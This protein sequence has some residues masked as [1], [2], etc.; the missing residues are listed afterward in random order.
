MNNEA[1]RQQ[2]L[3]RALWGDARP[4]VV[5]GWLRGAPQRITRGLQAYRAN[6][7]ALAERAL[8]AAFPT[9]AQLVGEESFAALARAFWQAQAPLKGDIAQW[10]AALPAFIAAAPQLADEPY[11]ADVARLDWAVHQAEQAAD[12]AGAVDGLEHLAACDPATLWLHL[13]DGVALIASPHPV[14]SIWQAHRSDAPDRF[15]PVREAFIRGQG[16]QAVVHRTGFKVR[17][18][19]VPEATARFVQA[20]AGGAPLSRALD[21][22]GP[23]F[24]FDGWLIQALQQHWL[25][26]I[27]WRGPSR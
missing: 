14:V 13:A 17:V 4:G 24:A 1:L 11:L 20:L 27:E 18:S 10:G 15:A 25:R 21:E 26:S 22:G 3:L 7:G 2:M 6:A 12:S 16:E 9:V 8:G 23:D 19:A 5:T